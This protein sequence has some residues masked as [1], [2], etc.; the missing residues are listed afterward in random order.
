MEALYISYIYIFH[1]DGNSD[2]STIES[3]KYDQPIISD[4][5]NALQIVQYFEILHVNNPFHIH[6]SGKLP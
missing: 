1:F 3:N 5:P 2:P 6:I 4:T